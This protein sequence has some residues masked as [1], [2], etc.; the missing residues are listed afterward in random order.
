MN[1]SL[2]FDVTHSLSVAVGVTASISMASSLS[3]DFVQADCLIK[4]RYF[5]I[6][7]DQKKLL[8][9]DEAW[10]E[11][12]RRGPRRMVNVPPKVINDVKNFHTHNNANQADQLLSV[13]TTPSRLEKLVS[14]P[15]HDEDKDQSI[16]GTPIPWSQTPRRGP[17]RS[18]RYAEKESPLNSHPVASPRKAQAEG[19]LPAYVDAASSSAAQ[20]EGL[21][22]QPLEALSQESRAPVNRPAVRPVSTAS[23]R[24]G[25]TPPSAQLETIPRTLS[26]T[27]Q[28]DERQSPAERQGRLEE[29]TF[30]DEDLE[31]GDQSDMSKARTTQ[32]A[33]ATGSNHESS[34]TTIS[35]PPLILQAAS[36]QSRQP[37]QPKSSS[38]SSSNLTPTW[39]G[40]RSA[41]ATQ[42]D[43]IIQAPA[44]D[45]PLPQA[46]Q[47]AQRRSTLNS[48]GQSLPWTQHSP[49]VR[50]PY[51]RFRVA[52]PDYQESAGIFV[53]A[54]LNLEKLKR[55]L[56]LP[57]FVY[58]D[59]VRAFSTGYLQYISMSVISKAD[60]IL[61]AVQ[62]YNDRVKAM[63][64][65][66]KIITKENIHD[67]IKAHATEAHKVRESIGEAGVTVDEAAHEELN[68]ALANEIEQDE[69]G[70]QEPGAAE[71]DEEVSAPRD[72]MELETGSPRVKLA[73][74]RAPVQSEAA[75][76]SQVDPENAFGTN[77]QPP[78]EGMGLSKHLE[79]HSSLVREFNEPS[80]NVIDK[81]GKAA[82][83]L[84]Q[85]D[86]QMDRATE[87][88]ESGASGAEAEYDE[89]ERREPD[90]H[91]MEDVKRRSRMMS[92]KLSV[93]SSAPGVSRVTASIEDERPGGAK[94]LHRGSPSPSGSVASHDIEMGDYDML[95]EDSEEDGPEDVEIDRSK[96]LPEIHGQSPE[97]NL[98]QGVHRDG[99]V[100][101][102]QATPSPNKSLAARQSTRESLTKTSTPIGS[103]KDSISRKFLK[104]LQSL[105]PASS[106][107]RISKVNG[108]ELAHER[109][110]S[111]RSN[112]AQS[113]PA[114]RSQ[115]GSSGGES[116]TSVYPT[117]EIAVPSSKTT[118]L[119]SPN[120]NT[121]PQS[122]DEE[123]DAFEAS[124][125]G[126]PMP[127]PR[128]AARSSPAFMSGTRPRTPMVRPTSTATVATLN[129]N[130]IVKEVDTNHRRV[131]FRVSNGSVSGVGNSGSPVSSERSYAN[132]PL[133]KKRA[134]ETKEERSRRLKEHFR[135][136]STGK[137][138]SSSAVSK[139]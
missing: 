46:A 32:L 83:N 75:L 1:A 52:Y 22:F 79:H 47:A 76:V 134:N 119:I 108:D 98:A 12:L 111:P 124:V 64:Y 62:W 120:L 81:K 29:I 56:A 58:D 80:E 69:Q 127:P 93:S 13:Q 136:I 65:R 137:T 96:S 9:S 38:K 116:N 112:K 91:A 18:I 33:V 73:T 51:E 2:A 8:D 107:T 7:E 121:Q 59:F 71:R 66:Q 26:G 100:P 99:A 101:E 50:T 88:E 35:T 23:V 20:S 5:Q 130:E 39:E 10:S 41:M 36:N 82:R 86:I 30:P 131:V 16:D 115:A 125:R 87:E 106:R 15:S 28:S 45:L 97:A 84:I 138:P 37:R 72:T 3:Q 102:V 135:R 21:E 89:P 114:F 48:T 61:T 90:Y 117:K 126:P 49:D 92:P 123:S 113:P 6:P 42:L 31:P 132:I 17:D 40:R 104:P 77:L 70:A 19:K 109:P 44:S 68:E 34:A 63:R 78:L 128:R 43:N 27:G 24:P 53:S 54:L 118:A 57:E 67:M 11:N 25:A 4:R 94:G 74:T 103:E 129:Q 110:N 105:S 60:Q 95:D 122:S 55:D 133:S 85:S 139:Q 14:T